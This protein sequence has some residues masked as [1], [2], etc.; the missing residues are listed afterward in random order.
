[1]SCYEKA[2]SVLGYSLALARYPNTEV[3]KIAL[4]SLLKCCSKVNLRY[5][6]FNLDEVLLDCRINESLVQYLRTVNSI[7]PKHCPNRR[8][9]RAR[10]Q[11]IAMDRDIYLVLTTFIQLVKLFTISL[12]FLYKNKNYLL[13]FVGK[14]SDPTP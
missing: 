8:K 4:R 7:V 14:S 1:M 13:G 12:S 2:C 5:W 10:K 11:R 6:E 9:I 3:C